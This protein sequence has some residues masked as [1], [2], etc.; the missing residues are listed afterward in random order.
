MDEGRTI[1]EEWPIAEGGRRHADGWGG[2]ASKGKA[3]VEKAKAGG[4][5]MEQ[6]RPPAGLMDA[7]DSGEGQWCRRGLLTDG[8]SDRPCRRRECGCRGRSGNP[9]REFYEIIVASLE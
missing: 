7:A 5:I 2:R 3:K 1:V 6:R 9:S 8:K 4:A